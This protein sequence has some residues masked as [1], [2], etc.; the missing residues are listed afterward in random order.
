MECTPRVLFTLLAALSAAP[1][2][3]TWAAGF[4]ITTSG[5]GQWV[6]RTDARNQLHRSAAGGATTDATAAL[7]VQ[8]QALSASA[9]GSLVA[10]TSR[11][12]PGCIGLATFGDGRNHAAS[13]KTSWLRLDGAA[14]GPACVSPA[15]PVAA[16]MPM[17]LSGDGKRIAVGGAQVRVLEMPAMRNALTIP[18]GGDPVLELRFV[19][20]GRKLLVAQ[21][22]ASGELRFAVWDIGRRELFSYQRASAPAGPASSY[23]WHFAE[24]TGDLWL[25]P[26]AGAAT[27]VNLI[28]PKG[29]KGRPAAPQVVTP[30]AVNV[31]Q[32][33]RQRGAAQLRSADGGP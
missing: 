16:A 15:G 11:Y 21:R 25:V 14:G 19:D 27:S 9:D 17:A 30:L 8:A 3:S 12:A 1:A 31:K 18:T 22:A 10:Y 32:C 13:G 4:P 33:G 26:P 2:A 6:F 7:P 24:A 23:T 20:D 29:R 5:D 28:P